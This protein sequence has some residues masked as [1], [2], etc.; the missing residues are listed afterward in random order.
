MS[1]LME[2]VRAIRNARSE[3][4]V[5]PG[6]RIAALVAA[7]GQAG[8][9]RQQQAA[10]EMLAHV[11]G[12]QLQIAE[13]IEIKPDQALALVVPGYECY[14]PLAALIDLD[15]ERARLNAELAQ[16]E[17][18]LAR[19]DKLLANAGF[20]SKAPLAVVQKERDKLVEYA[21]RREKLQERLRALS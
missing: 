13:Q 8:F 2:L 18:D 19:A 15:K 4:N 16:L 11:D 17:Q 7:G 6:R 14:L 3:Y 10:F 9:L 21:A 12:A 1:G 20:V 5:E